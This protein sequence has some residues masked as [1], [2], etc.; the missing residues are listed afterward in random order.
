MTVRAY[1]LGKITPT[2]EAEIRDKLRSLPAVK[3][4]DTCFGRY[5]FI[6]VCEAEDIPALESGAIETMRG[7]P[8]ILSTETLIV[9]RIGSQKLLIGSKKKA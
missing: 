6:A 9:S 8:N 1:V 4:V 5:D 2:K 7:M 3:N